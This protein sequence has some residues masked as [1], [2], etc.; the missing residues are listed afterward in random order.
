ME[1]GH[2]IE[3]KYNIIEIKLLLGGFNKHGERYSYGKSIDPEQQFAPSIWT[4][5]KNLSDSRKRAYSHDTFVTQWA[6]V[7]VGG[8]TIVAW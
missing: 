2:Q 8:I 5:E 7:S 3:Q 4:V 1:L 6:I